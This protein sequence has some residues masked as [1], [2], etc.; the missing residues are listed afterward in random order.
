MATAKISHSY[1]VFSSD[2]VADIHFHLLIKKNEAINIKKDIVNDFRNVISNL[3]IDEK[4]EL[5]NQYG[6]PYF[7]LTKPMVF[8]DE[9]YINMTMPIIDASI[10]QF[11]K[12]TH[13]RNKQR[14]A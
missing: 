7:D 6:Q 11:M 2:D 10:L 12:T 9:G 3:I 4:I 1:G 13:K 14:S 5:A 8:I